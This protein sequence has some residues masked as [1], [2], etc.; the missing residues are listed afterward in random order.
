MRADK[1]SIP[2]ILHLYGIRRED[3]ILMEPQIHELDEGAGYIG[4]REASD[5]IGA[6]IGPLG[7]EE[8]P[9]QLSIHRLAATDISAQV[10]Y[11]SADISLKD[12]F[13]VYSADIA[14]ASGRRGISLNI[15]GSAFAGSDFDG[16]VTP[17]NAVRV[18]SGASIPDGA[19]AVAA[20]EFCREISRQEVQIY[21]DADRGRN[22]LRSGG[23]V[24]AGT[25]IVRRGDLFSPGVMGL[26]AAAG[27]SNVRVCRRPKAAI[28]GIGDEIVS[29]GTLLR[30][31]QVYASNLVTLKAWLNHFD[32]ECVT[33]VVRDN[34]DAIRS[35]L[36]QKRSVVDVILTS[37]GAW[38]SERDLVIGALDDLGWKKIFHHVRMGPGKGISFG[39]W[40]TMPVFCLPGGPA[41]NA[42]AFLQLALPG[43]LKMAGDVR[44]P[45]P[46]VPATLTEDIKGRNKTWT[47]FKDAV[48]SKTAEGG[49]TVSLYQNRSRL[50]AIARANSL[51]CIPEGSACLNR[52][53]RIRVQSLI[54][55]P[56]A[57]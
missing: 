45:L 56:D 36:V 32:I 33:S 15:I 44:P 54:S 53:E 24:E 27:I 57:L 50:Q 55:R 42:M 8:I 16:R 4:Y 38:G 43:I 20:A 34:V 13:A 52:G 23:E 47:E 21:A 17:G 37:G 29:P 35:E 51:I 1:D 9:L 39:K 30:P 31:G 26:A 3:S 25:P 28:V 40:E 48:L 22:I 7:S 6:N 5:L 14:E 49:Y 2:Y 19:D 10:S 18:C 12:G 11:P 41:S 46:L